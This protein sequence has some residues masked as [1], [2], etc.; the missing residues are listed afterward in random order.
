MGVVLATT[1]GAR[2]ASRAQIT[3]AEVLAATGLEGEAV[4]GGDTVSVNWS[5]GDHERRN[6]EEEDLSELHVEGLRLG[7]A[8]VMDEVV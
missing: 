8:V 6:G 2:S 5:S 4:D 1:E 7:F 3:S